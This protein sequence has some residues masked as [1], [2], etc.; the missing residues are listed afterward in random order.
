[1]VLNK[2]VWCGGGEG[3]GGIKVCGVGAGRGGGLQNV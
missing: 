1:M 3:G 2:G